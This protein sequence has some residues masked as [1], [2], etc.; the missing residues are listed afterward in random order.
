MSDEIVRVIYLELD[1]QHMDARPTVVDLFC[2]GGGFSE[3]LRQ[4]GFDVTLAI[5]DDPAAVRTHEL[6]HPETDTIEADVMDIEP[7]LLPDDVDVMVGSPPCTE[8][9]WAKEGG[10]G[11]IDAGM[12]LVKRFLHLVREVEPDH[13]IMENVPR[14][15]DYL[16]ETIDHSDIP[17]SNRD[18][19]VDI[20]KVTLDCDDYRTPQRR[21]RLFSG[22]FPI[23]DPVADPVPSFGAINDRFPTP[24]ADVPEVAIDDPTYDIELPAG[25]L[26]DHFY[27]SFLTE[28]EAEEIRV[29]KEDHSFY[30]RMRFPDDPNVPSRTV[31]ATNR[32]IARETLVMEGTDPPDGMSRYRKPTIREIATIQGFPINYQF[33]GATQAKKWRRVGDA[34]PPTIAYAIGC[35]IR[36][37]MGLS[38]PKN[39]NLNLETPYPETVLDDRGAASKGRRRLSISRSF[40]H[41]V[42]MDEMRSF[43]VD[44]ETDKDGNPQ[45]P[46][47]DQVAGWFFHPVEFEVVLY[48]GY[49]TDVVSQKIDLE[50]IMAIIHRS[51][52][53][54]PGLKPIVST[55]VRGLLDELGPITPDAT[56]LQAIRSR[57]TDRDEPLEYTLL[58]TISDYEGEGIVDRALP[59]ETAESIPPISHPHL[60]DGAEIPVRVLLKSLGAT[61]LS[62]RLN[63]CARWIRAHPGEVYLPNSV[64]A[65]ASELDLTSCSCLRT[66]CVDET[67]RRTLID[68]RQPSHATASTD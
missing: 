6:N 27:N 25:G 29:R 18:D 49:S 66:R 58:S 2:G 17:W 30:G 32:R 57:R 19:T 60:F 33:T 37:A 40:R 51:I 50:I 41:H 16:P 1:N 43:R 68:E 20:T 48:R 15:D 8:F 11:D 28:R 35:A 22:S 10:N 53:D 56:T 3:G 7:G 62:T 44:L 61:Y 4:A 26:M 24:T 65:P 47:S 55:V 45:H 14:L 52:E 63:R 54:R 39:P 59:Q 42:P 46:L 34:V 12:R 13:W 64:E 38:V 67:L 31:V 23:P 36:D 5:D 9:S 21:S